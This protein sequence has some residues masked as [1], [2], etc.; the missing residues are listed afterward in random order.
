MLA[1]YTAR[2]DPGLATQVGHDSQ[3]ASK[4]VCQTHILMPLC[5]QSL[6]TDTV[7][8]EPSSA[9]SEPEPE[10]EPGRLKRLL[11]AVMRS[12]LLFVSSVIA[13]E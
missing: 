5:V 4:T 1:V 8:D 10:P 6:P 2:L 11:I 3:I 13:P 9:L 7:H 12:G